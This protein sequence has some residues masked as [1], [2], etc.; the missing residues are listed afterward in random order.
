M[1][2]PYEVIIIGDMESKEDC[3]RGLIH[4]LFTHF[5]EQT[6]LMLDVISDKFKIDKEELSYTIKEDERIK[7]FVQKSISE[8][9]IPPSTIKSKSGK[10]IIIK[11]PN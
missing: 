8:I 6:N 3:L 9:T 2:K 5:A 10:K 7:E 1:Q 11:K 4:T